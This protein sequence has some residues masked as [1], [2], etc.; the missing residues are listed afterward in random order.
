MGFI[1]YYNLFA[2]LEKPQPGL[3]WN[4]KLD[5]GT[6][7]DLRHPRGSGD[8]MQGLWFFPGFACWAQDLQDFNVPLKRPGI[9]GP[10]GLGVWPGLLEN[11]R[12]TAGCQ[13]AAV[14][15]GRNSVLGS[16]SHSP[17]SCLLGRPQDSPGV[18]GWDHPRD[19]AQVGVWGG[20]LY[21]LVCWIFSPAW[22]VSAKLGRLRDP[23]S[24]GFWPLCSG[25]N[26]NSV[27]IPGKWNCQSFSVRLWWD[28]RGVSPSINC[29]GG[30]T[31]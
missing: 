9:P 10:A 30:S 7:A 14:N 6:L 2:T 26:A 17:C 8:A 4:G 23:G 1:H 27:F 19:C 25:R 24:P 18:L 29:D 16:R 21:R 11:W 3:K 13:E 31:W 15:P 22:R 20:P 5:R 12:E 28:Q